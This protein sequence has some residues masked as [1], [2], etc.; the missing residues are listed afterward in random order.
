MSKT[1]DCILP[2]PPVCE[3]D[4]CITHGAAENALTPYLINVPVLYRSIKTLG[5]TRPNQIS[6][7]VS[8]RM[9][10]TGGEARGGG[11]GGQR[12]MFICGMWTA[13]FGGLICS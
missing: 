7:S 3:A 12:L 4:P 8:M 9:R 2:G 13:A 6:V 10:G 1:A 11:G 5:F